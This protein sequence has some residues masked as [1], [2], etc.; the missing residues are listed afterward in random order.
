MSFTI[1]IS[2]YATS[3]SAPCRISP[4]ILLVSLGQKLQSLLNPLR[5]PLQPVARRIAVVPP[6]N[7]AIDVLRRHAF[8]PRLPNQLCV[9]R[10]SPHAPPLS[11]CQDSFSPL[12]SKSQTLNSAP[13]LVT[14]NPSPL[15]CEGLERIVTVSSTR[16]ASDSLSGNALRN[17]RSISI[18]RFSVV[19]TRSTKTSSVFRFCRSNGSS[20]SR[21]THPSSSTRSVTIP[22]TAS[23]SP[24]TSTSTV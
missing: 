24:P 16:T 9:S 19:G 4:G 18:H 2:S 21:P 14:C 6:D 22:V 23:N 10:I 11:P 3:N 15:T 12:N 8:Q 5:R 20:T 17:R 7:L 13:Q 1:T